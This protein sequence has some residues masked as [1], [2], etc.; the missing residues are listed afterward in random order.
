MYVE[1]LPKFETYIYL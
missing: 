1:S